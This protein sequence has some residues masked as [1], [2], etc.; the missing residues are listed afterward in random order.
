MKNKTENSEVA[1]HNRQANV[2]ESSLHPDKTKLRYWV[3]DG[4]C[5]YS[6]SQKKH[7][8]KFVEESDIVLASQLVPDGLRLF[9]TETIYEGTINKY[10]IV[11]E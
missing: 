1:S 6:F 10:K 11:V 8:D 3:D 5:F 7:R 4:D 9:T 2:S